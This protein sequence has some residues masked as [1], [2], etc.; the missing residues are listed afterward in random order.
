MRVPE[1]VREGWH[2]VLEMA[3]TMP[4][5]PAIVWE[6]ITDWEHQDDWMLE[7]RDFTVLSKKREG[8]GVEAEATIRVAG[9]TTRDKVRVI[10]WDPPRRLVIE[11]HGWVSGRGEMS[12]TPLKGNR[13]H[14]FWR[15][16]LYPPIGIFGSVG[17]TALKPVMGRIFG[18]DLKILAGLVRAAARQGGTGN[19]KAQKRPPVA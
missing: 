15:E 12:L 2:V 6:L 13:T 17:M 14:L 19:P 8:V 10:G 18:R 5:P 16:E 7:A 1:V 3:E 4:G 11:H 9:I